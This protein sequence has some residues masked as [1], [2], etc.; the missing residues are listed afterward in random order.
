M[1]KE[2]TG[3]T[4]KYFQN[5]IEQEVNSVSPD[6]AFDILNKT[7][8]ATPAP[9]KESTTG[10]VTRTLKIDT[11]LFTVMGAEINSG[12]LTSGQKY[13]VT[14]GTIGSHAVG[15]I[16]QSD[17]TETCDTDNKVKPLGEKVTGKT[18]AVTFDSSSFL[19]KKCDYNI[20][21]DKLSK[22]TS[23]TPPPGKEITTGRFKSTTQLEALMYR[24]TADLI[25][26][27]SP[28]VKPVVITFA[29]GV[30]VSGNALVHQISITD[31][32]EGIVAVTYNI[33]WQGVPVE[34]GIGYLAMATEQSCE[35]IFE[36]GASTN[37]GFTGI[38]ILTDRQISCDVEGDATISS[39]GTLNGAIT[40][41]VYS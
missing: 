11:Y 3:K 12:T 17:G 36:K 8:S 2:V 19:M 25:E 30:T 4:L 27:S 23:V 7:T 20:S 16:F 39:T 21:Y 5:G 14:L 38:I 9:G 33:E 22:T 15:E 31:E 18:L 29:P 32:V 24:E 35:V 40:P 28:E 34:T 13:L 1:G 37:K 10:R 41:T 26:N 6:F